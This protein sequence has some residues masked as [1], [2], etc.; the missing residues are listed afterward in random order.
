M[1]YSRLNKKSPRFQERLILN[2]KCPNKRLIHH[3]K[4]KILN[5]S[6]TFVCTFGDLRLK[7]KI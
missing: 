6:R 1:S 4:K 7:K 2:E 3:L 5:A